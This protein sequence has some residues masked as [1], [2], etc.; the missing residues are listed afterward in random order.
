MEDYDKVMKTHLNISK[1]YLQVRPE[2][3]IR[4]IV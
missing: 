1:R 3:I 2:S 4:N